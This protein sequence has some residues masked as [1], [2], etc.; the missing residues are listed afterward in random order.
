MKDKK[1]E[2]LRLI[3]EHFQTKFGYADIG[4]A[5]GIPN[6]WLHVNEYTKILSFEPNPDNSSK[7]PPNDSAQC[8]SWAVGK[9]QIRA[10]LY[11][12]KLPETSSLFKPNF[13]LLKE[14]GLEDLFVSTETVSVQVRPLDSLLEEHGPNIDFCGID[15]QGSD[16]DVLKGATDYLSQSVI[17]IDVEVSFLP[18]TKT[19]RHSVKFMPFS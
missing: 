16:L 5:G 12:N 3:G 4:G 2:I 11:M 17:G 1:I 10:E 9:E 13:K 14:F 8:F 6:R 7:L 15:T 18:I 19:C